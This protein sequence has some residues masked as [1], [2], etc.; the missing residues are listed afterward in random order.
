MGVKSEERRVKNSFALVLPS[1]LINI[2]YNLK[3]GHNHEC[4]T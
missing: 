4:D 2:N 1:F 3:K